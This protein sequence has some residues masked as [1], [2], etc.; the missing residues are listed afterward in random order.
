MVFGGISRQGKT[1]LWFKPKTLA[2]DTDVYIE[3][4]S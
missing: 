1:K 3:T 2:I 4:M